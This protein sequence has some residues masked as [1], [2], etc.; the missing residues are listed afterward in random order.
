MIANLGAEG[1]KTTKR[2]AE[3]LELMKLSGA[4]FDPLTGALKIGTEEL[5]TLAE[6]IKKIESPLERIK[7]LMK[8]GLPEATARTE[9]PRLAA[10]A[11]AYRKQVDEFKRLSGNLS[12]AQL[13]YQRKVSSNLQQALA[14][15]EEVREAG[16]RSTG[17][18]VAE[19]ITPLIN[20]LKEAT[21][22]FNAALDKLI[23]GFG[24]QD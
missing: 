11:D 8:A 24:T 18:I 22:L 15:L 13:E 21:L 17:L 3:L 23:I 14:G 19:Q 9:A 4:S 12:D 10:G 5:A 16:R 20:D 6:N 2:M 1:G 7:A